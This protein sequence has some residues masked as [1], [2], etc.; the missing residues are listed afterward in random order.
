MPNFYY[1]K[2]FDNVLL[3]FLDTTVFDNNFIH[4]SN[5]K[6]KNI[7][8]K[9]SYI[10]SIEQ[11]NWLSNDLSLNKNKKKIIFGHYPI[12]TNGLYKYHVKPIYDKL[13]D[14]F[15]NNKVDF[16]I[17]GHEHNIQFIKKKIKNYNFK[18]IILG[19]S[20]EF[21]NDPDFSTLN[22]LYDKTDN[23]YGLLS[24]GKKNIFNFINKNGVIKYE[25]IT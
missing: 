11:L 1:K 20:S 10:L 8:N 3:Y 25:Y 6:I 18:Q 15:Y 17:S 24:L 21:R 23:Y 9:N 2:E 14:I 22:N 16:Y 13:I 19:S 5:S 12:I 4:I 7:H